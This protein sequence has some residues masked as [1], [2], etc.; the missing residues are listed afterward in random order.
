M[1]TKGGQERDVLV[2]VQVSGRAGLHEPDISLAPINPEDI[3]EGMNPLTVAEPKL[4]QPAYSVGY[5]AGDFSFEDFLPVERT[6]TG[7]SENSLYGAYH[8]DG[9]G[10][11]TP[12]TGNGQ[13]GSPIL[14]HFPGQ[15][16][17]WKVVGLH[18]GHLLDW[19][20][21]ANS[22]GSGVNLSKILPQLVTDNLPARELLFQTK[23]VTR[24]Q[25]NE[26]VT[27]IALI[28]NGNV[29]TRKHM[30]L[31]SH[32]YDDLHAEMALWGE[33]LKPGDVVEFTIQRRQDVEPKRSNRKSIFF[34]Q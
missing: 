11:L 6:F 23:K 16:E 13:C 1:P 21:A 5:M 27:E 15:T 19:E 26:R 2:E 10:P 4:D 34:V 14:Q 25:P 17:E 9:S 30:K 28:R 31:F 8:I 24:L 20:N 22:R 29:V 12:L 18:N 3:P 7:M 32:P 33:T